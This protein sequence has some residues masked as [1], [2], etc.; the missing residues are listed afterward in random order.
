MRRR[1]SMKGGSVQA[2]PTARA[3]RSHAWLFDLLFGGDAGG[4]VGS[5]RRPS[6]RVR[7]CGAVRRAPGR[8][9]P[10]LHGV[11]RQP[12][13]CFVCPDLLQH[14]AHPPQAAGAQHVGNRPAGRSAWRATGSRIDVGIAAQATAADLSDALISDYLRRLFGRDEVVVAFGGGSGPYRK[15]VLQVFAADG[16]PLGY[17]KVGWNA[18]S[19]DAVGREATA[20][21]ACAA[22]PMR[23]LGVPALIDRRDW[24]GLDL[25]VTAPLPAGVRRLGRGWGLP[26]AAVL[27]GITEL[28]P[29]HAGPLA[30]SPYWRGIR[31]RIEATRSPGGPS[32]LRW[33]PTASSWPAMRCCRSAAGTAIWCR[34]TWPGSATAST[35]GTGRA[36]LPTRRSASTPCTTTS[37]WRSSPGGTPLAEAAA[38]AR[39]QRRPGAAC[40]RRG[41]GR[42]RPARR[43]ASAGAGAPARA[44]AAST[45]DV[46]DRFYPARSP[47][48]ILRADERDAGS[49]RHEGAA[50]LLLGRAPRAAAQPAALVAAARPDLGHLRWRASRLAARR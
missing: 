46:D 7:A 13:R 38:L 26:D 47:R 31:A 34:G 3:S 19:R 18:W 2:S 35:P 4:V 15:P 32:S 48:C 43:S 8:A 28:T 20:L 41:G 17:V 42:R 11:A 21:T 14:A 30:A 49:R 33:P 10:G 22:R 23:L 40:A 9:V 1:V 24:R 25:V 27:R 39:R 5:R 45:G 12:A 37:R 6:G 29:G 16:S 44:G 36:A 50:G